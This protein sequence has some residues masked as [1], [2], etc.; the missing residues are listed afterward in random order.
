MVSKPDKSILDYKKDIFRAEVTKAA[1]SLKVSIPVIKFWSHYENHFNKGERAH[2]HIEKGIICIAEQELEIMTEEDIRTTATHEVSHLHHLNHGPEFQYTQGNLELTNWERPSGTVGALPEGYIRQKE[3]DNTKS[4]PIKYKCNLCGKKVETKKCGYC[5]Y[6]FCE[7][8]LRAKPAGLPKFT[9]TNPK[10]LAFMEEFH[11]EGGHPCIPFVTHWIK[12]E[13]KESERYGIA[14]DK[15]LSKGKNIKTRDL[16]KSIHISM[17]ENED[18]TDPQDI[19]E[20][21]PKYKDKKI[22]KSRK[23][24][25]WLFLIIGLMLLIFFV[26]KY[27]LFNNKLDNSESKEMSDIA[28]SEINNI[29]QENSINKLRYDFNSYNLAITIAEKFYLSNSYTIS[30][31][32]LISL[33]IKCSVDNPSLLSTKLENLTK[34]D[35]DL[36]VLGWTTK[37]IFTEKTF[38]NTFNEGA[39]GCY[40]ESCVL[41][42][43]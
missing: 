41:I 20:E 43:H 33:S 37:E 8:H 11:K 1:I 13:K 2:I 42:L 32:E 26:V 5:E 28:F 40:K 3:K 19:D 10:D 35:F 9:S 4:K 6:Y 38:N 24:I 27:N 21:I 18:F 15:F 12:K 36:M 39:L 22:K 29:R 23:P 17:H 25:F 7:N 16:S 30:K 34:S 31:S 14:L